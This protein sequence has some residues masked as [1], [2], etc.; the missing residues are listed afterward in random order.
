LTKLIEESELAADGR[1]QDPVHNGDVYT[2]SRLNLEVRSLIESSYPPIWVQGEVSN[3]ARPRSGH[4]YFSL[5]DNSCQV[6]C[7]MFRMRNRQLEFD[8][9]DGM[10]VLAN[11]RVSL[12][13]ERGEFQLIVQYM[14]EA[15]AGALR[16][17]F[18]ALKLRL[19]AEGL[20]D[21]EKKRPLPEF[22]AVIGVVTSPTGAALRD[23]LHVIQRRHPGVQVVIYPVPVQGAQAAPEIVRMIGVAG[24][25]G[26]CDVLII[27]RG[28]GSIEDLWAFNQEQL[29][30]AIRA[31]PVPVVTGIGHEVDFT[32]AD[33]AADRRAP[34]PSAAAEL[35]TPDVRHLVTRIGSSRQRLTTLMAAL[36]RNQRENLGRLSKRLLLPRRRLL[37]F[38]QRVDELSL[39]LNRSAR[40]APVSRRAVLAALNAR[41]AARHPAS[42]IDL[43]RARHADLRR[44]LGDLAS[45]RLSDARARV[46]ETTR[47]L[48]SISPLNTLERGYS[49]LTRAEDGA[50]LSAAES[51]KR[52][53]R[54]HA[55]LAKG[56]LELT[57]ER[58]KT[59]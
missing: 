58:K 44:R 10:Q 7:A 42:Q 29:A 51:V 17:A 32:I 13:P 12:Y 40:G 11:A 16:R 27:A 55:R 56:E 39:R 50:L 22:P 19:A 24:A 54:V 45:R 6:R 53:Q 31:C 21:E 2:V 34:T 8:P 48:N 4:I 37:D 25:R 15:G 1:S 30:R 49:I 14:E 43:H 41:L 38:T 57:V 28:G 36:I 5:K 46:S 26:D 52:G 35:V 23:I 9:E 20:F 33:F 47:A 3:L 59:N 18:E